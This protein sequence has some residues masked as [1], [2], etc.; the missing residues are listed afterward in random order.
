MEINRGTQRYR[1]QHHGWKNWR[2]CTGG[3][4]LCDR[5]E[6]VRDKDRNRSRLNATW[7]TFETATLR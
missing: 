4:C 1:K 7:Q 5:H 6:G 2:H 3:D